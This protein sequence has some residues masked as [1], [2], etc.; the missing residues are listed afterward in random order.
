MKRHQQVQAATGNFVEAAQSLDQHHGCLGH[1]PDRLDR[2]DQQHD[3]DETKNKGN[4][5]METGGRGKKNWGFEQPPELTA[6]Q[7]ERSTSTARVS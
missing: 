2:N 3:G 6:L 5:K 1:D 7:A 4:L